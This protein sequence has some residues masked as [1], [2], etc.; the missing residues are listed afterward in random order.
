[1]KL[2]ITECNFF[3]N[4]KDWIFKLKDEDNSTFYILAHDFYKALNLKS[5]LNK[6]HLD[7]YNNGTVIRAEIKEFGGKKVVIAIL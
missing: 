2:T 7:N 3:A 1:M 6:N 5:P 4:G